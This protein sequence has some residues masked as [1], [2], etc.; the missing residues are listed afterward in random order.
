MSEPH[1][2]APPRWKLHAPSYLCRTDRTL[3]GLRLFWSRNDRYFK[4]EK[5][6]TDVDKIDMI[7]QLLLDPEL[8][9]WYSSDAA[10]HVNKKYGVFQRDLT[11]RALPS[12]YMWQHYRR[13]DNLRQTGDYREF[14]TAARD[15]QLELGVSLVSDTQ[16]VRMLLLHMDEELSQRLRLSEV[17]KG[18]GL[19]PDKLDASIVKADST[20]S[21]AVFD[22][23][24]FDAEARRLWQ[25]ISATRASVKATAQASAKTVR[26]TPTLRTTA[27]PST[28]PPLSSKTRAPPMTDRERAFLRSN[29]GCFKCRKINAG[30]FKDTCTTWATSACKVP[31]GWRQDKIDDK[32]EELHCLCDDEYDNGTDDERCEPISLSVKLTTEDGPA[33][34]ALV[35]TGASASFIADREVEK[36]RLTRRKLQV[37][38]SV[39]VAIQSHRV[40]HPV[41]EFVCVPLRTLNGRW[42]TQHVVLKIAP[43]TSLKVVLGRPFLKRHDILVDWKRRRVLAPDPTLPGKRIDLMH[44]GEK[45][46]WSESAVQA[47][48]RACLAHLE[49]QQAEES[50]LRA[51]EVAFRKEFSDR[52]PADI[53]PVSQY[54]SKVRHRI[55]LK[56]GMKT[57]R[58]PTYGT[59]MRWRAAW[60]RLLDE[61]LAAGRLRPS[62]SEY[63]SSAFIIPKKGMD[64]DPSIMP[65]WVNDYRILNAA[66][67][68]DRTPLPLPDEIL[69]VAA[70]ARFWSKIDMTNSFFQTK[71]AEEDIPKTAVATPWGLFEWVV[72]PMGLSNAPATHQRRVNEALSS[73]IGKSCFAYLDDITIFSDTME[74]HQIHVKEVL[75]ALRR[76]DLY[77]S[78]KKTEL[79]RTSCDFLGHVISRNG[80]AADQS[81]VERIVGWPRP[82]TVTELRGFLGLVQYL[83]KFI[84]GL[85]QHTKPLA[86]LTS[87]NA[88]VRLMWGAEQERH[89]NAIKA[90][91]TSLPCLKP[92]DHTDSADPL[93]VMTDA[94]N[95]GIGAVLLQGQDW[96]KAHPVAYWSRQYISAEVNYPTHEQEFL[97]VVDALRQWR[98][99]LMGVHFHV[100]SDHESLK[101]LKTQENLSKR[102]ARWVE[103]LADYDFDITYIPGGENTVADT[104]SRYSFPQGEPDS[105][106]AVSEMDIDTQL[107]GRL[108]EGYD[109]DPFCQQVKRNLDSSPGFSCVDGVLYFEG[110]MVVP[111]VPQLREDILHDAHNAL[112]HFSPCKTFH[113][114]SR[115]FFWP[116]LQTSCNAY[117]STCDVCQ[118]TK[119]TTTGA[120][121][122][123]H[124]LAVPDGLMQEVALDFV[125]P[126][127]KSQGFDMLLTIT[128]RLSGYTRLIPSLAADTAKDIAERFHEG[129][130]RF[131]GP[132]TRIVSDRDKLFT[133]HFWRAYHNL[134][135]TR[136]AMS[137]SFHPE[138]DGRSERTNK[139]AI[140]ALRA[141]VNKQQNNWVRHL[142]NIEFAINASVNASTKIADLI[143]ERK[144][145]LAEVRDA[146]AAAKVR[147]AEQVNR[148]RRPEPDIAVGDFVMVDTRDRRLRF[149]TGH[150]KSA[151]LFDRFEGPYKVIAANVATSNY[152]LQLSEGDRS[153]PTFHVSKLRPYRANDPNLFPN[154]EPARPKPVI[155][156]G[157]EEW[158]VREILEETTRG[159]KRYRV[160]WEGYLQHEATMEPRENLVGTEALRCWEL[161]KRMEGRVLVNY[162]CL[163]LSFHFNPP[164]KDYPTTPLLSSTTSVGRLPGPLPRAYFTPERLAIIEDTQRLYPCQFNF[165]RT[166][167]DLY[168]GKLLAEHP[169]AILVNS[170]LSAFRSEGFESPHD[171]SNARG[172]DP[173]SVRFP[174]NKHHREFIQTTVD[175]EVKK[176]WVS[177]GSAFPLP[178][179]TYNSIFVVEST[180]HRIRVVADHTSSGLND[181]IQRTDCPTIYDTIIDFI[182]LLRW[183]RFALGLLTDTSVL[184]KLDVS[185]AF[186]ILIMSKRWQARQ[187]IAI[188]RKLSDGTLRTWYHIEW[189][190]VFGCRAMPFL[191]TRFMSLLMWAAHNVYGIEHPLAYMDDAFGIDLAGSMVAY[192]HNGTTHTIPA[193]QAAMAAL[194]TGL[195][196]P[197]KLSP[198]KA[199]HGRRITITGIDCDLDSFSVS[200]PHKAIEDLLREIDVFLLKPS[201]HPTLRKWRQMTG[202]LSWSL[203]VAPQARPYLT[204]LYEKL[205]GKKRSDVG[206]PINTSTA[207]VSLAGACLKDADVVIYTD[208]C[209]QNATG[210]GAGLGFWFEW[211]GTVHHYYCRPQQTY[212]RIQFAETL[213]VVLALG[214]VTHPSSPFKPLSRVLVRTDSAPAVY[215]VDS[216]AAKDGDFMPLRTL[217]L[218]SYVM[219]QHRKFDLKVIHVHGKDN[220][221]AD[222]L[223]R[224]HEVQLHRRFSP[225][226][227]FDPFI[228][229]LEGVSL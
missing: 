104:M 120:L 149:K 78:P 122:V 103:R 228:P 27:S 13:L 83:R 207:Q 55:A 140:Q 71:M 18:T 87:K 121:G 197:F 182:R 115:T 52:F 80:I 41:T 222:D 53:P 63:S 190:G 137:T 29:Q 179:V 129:W 76:A 102:Q 150:R 148:H 7:G 212:K 159:G 154:R 166:I 35:D 8:K 4:K 85:A 170:F 100:L 191:W 202:W 12:D 97:A 92:I 105:V 57:P 156:D 158:V 60:R 49:E 175:E 22:Y 38:T 89:F 86:D 168:L 116:R 31:A 20:T 225:L 59:P 9:V 213:T 136:L 132:P 192:N 181:G 130:H 141:V 123:L 126:L 144:A 1:E 195:G 163:I 127:P 151:K 62:S 180:N 34:R 165:T 3:S 211:K 111:A 110:R 216:G 88:N 6:E 108:V 66:T 54:E 189:R 187:G 226:T 43:L 75:E 14:S 194:W 184:W 219:A 227:H 91:V 174:K 229:G 114:M 2:D 135:G 28:L 172:D 37:P 171:G 203:N 210:T 101:Y 15:L 47:S 146:L 199:P 125:G 223:L 77:C 160:W 56:P 128:D 206:V 46:E 113:Q 42:S 16:L 185:S 50:Q 147:Q 21:S 82:R 44:R 221:L 162:Y 188:K 117:V 201:R 58:Q 84:N 139:T 133:S 142:V 178:G 69:A 138:T 45:G 74:D 90:I 64:T 72:M 10:S 218:R 70:R 200:L 143:A 167:N 209:L 19:S 40:S 183:H 176:Q 26:S 205:A 51:L 68:P 217:T 98:V 169:N 73:L 93:W 96:R 155:V 94:S 48:I 177:P 153:H 214:I 124:A 95:V 131:F 164:S 65:R 24:T 17:I 106:Q 61:H 134:M 109:S 157:H 145:V 36:L 107:R 67:V 5:I 32:G 186:K 119:A 173:A 208:A 193:Q 220:T 152:T 30:H 161:K 79:F 118:R 112:G 81:K 204:P 224:Q 39:S 33:L 23:Q 215:A 196:M 11:L 198:D 25:V 99:N